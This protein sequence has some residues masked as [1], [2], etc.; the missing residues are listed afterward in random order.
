MENNENLKIEILNNQDKNR[1]IKNIEIPFRY[2]SNTFG[3]WFIKDLKS[4]MNSNS[5]LHKAYFTII[6][7]LSLVMIIVIYLIQNV[8]YE[9]KVLLLFFLKLF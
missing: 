2:V 7:I 8:N 4:L 5:K 3:H 6:I 1:M 9:M